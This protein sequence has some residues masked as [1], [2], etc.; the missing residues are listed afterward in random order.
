MNGI[1][2][3]SAEIR[4]S[5]EHSAKGDVKRLIRQKAEAATGRKMTNK[6]AKKWLRRQ[7]RTKHAT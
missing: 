4:V 6:A 5:G 2:D 7:T 3:P 1:L